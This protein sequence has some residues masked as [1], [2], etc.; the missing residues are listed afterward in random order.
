MKNISY[1]ENGPCAT[2]GGKY[3]Y[4]E[5]TYI[6]ANG[7][8]YF[9][10]TAKCDCGI[11]TLMDNG[12]HQFR[13]HFAKCARCRGDIS[14]LVLNGKWKIKHCD[15]GAYV[16]FF[17][18]KSAFIGTKDIKFLPVAL[19]TLNMLVE[20]MRDDDVPAPEG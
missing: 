5:K 19:N 20:R 12:Q 11:H 14:V 16:Y 6:N 18:G 1:N 4:L 15:C 3:T 9:V 17:D 7:E 10:K 8:K 13:P 2:C